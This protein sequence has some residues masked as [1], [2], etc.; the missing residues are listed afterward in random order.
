MHTDNVLTKDDLRTIES[1]INESASVPISKKFEGKWSAVV[2]P[3]IVRNGFRIF[4]A[5]E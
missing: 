1:I 5:G 4:T 3:D 2:D